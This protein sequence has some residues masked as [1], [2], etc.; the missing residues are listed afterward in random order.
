VSTAQ[1]QQKQE[2]LIDIAT[3]LST[4]QRSQLQLKAN[5]LALQA[6]ATDLDNNLANEQAQL[7][8]SLASLQQEIAE[9]S[10]RKANL[11]TASQ[12]G[13]ITALNYPAGQ[14]VT[15]GQSLATLLP[16]QSDLE[17]QLYAPSRT[18]GFVSVGQNVLIRYQAF[19]YQKFGLHHGT[20]TDVSKTPFAPNELPA[21][22][23]ST[24]LSNAQQNIQGFNSN[25]ALYR[26]KV[27]LEKQS[28]DAYGK[29]QMLKPGMTL[30]A[31]VV[32]DSRKIWEWVLEPVLAVLQR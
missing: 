31:D 1:T 20:V 10:N 23:A 12:D 8:R 6:E 25:E 17:V 11:L 5:Q 30:E 28:I 22:L 29:P 15:A 4:L 13:I 21:N 32:Q 2:D 24:I 27:R 3:R 18:A 26:I 7:A 9:N 19:P 14:T 16:H